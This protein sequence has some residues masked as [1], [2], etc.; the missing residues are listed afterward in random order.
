MAARDP[1][2]PIL[3]IGGTGTVGSRLVQHPSSRCYP[4]IAASQSRSQT[5]DHDHGI[6][7]D[8]H[9][10]NTWSNPFSAAGGPLRAVYIVASPVMDS[11]PITMEFIDF[12]RDKCV[13]RFVLREL[14]QRGEVDWAVL[15]PTW[16]QRGPPSPNLFLPLPGP[17][18]FFSSHV[19]L[20]MAI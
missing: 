12:A 20:T 3:V 6:V 16:F 1:K 18:P 15:R 8:W 5:G 10:H 7:F 19:L 14:G 2:P 4:V 17:P 13:R 9:D 11:A